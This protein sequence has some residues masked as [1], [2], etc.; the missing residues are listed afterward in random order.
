MPACGTVSSQAMSEPEIWCPKCG[1]RPRAEDR[2]ICMPGCDTSWNTFWTAGL[3]PGCM[4]RWHNTQC[5]VCTRISPHRDWYHWPQP[6]EADQGARER[7]GE[8]AGA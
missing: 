8:A 6:S 2:W 3:C 1:W 7:S 5:L 4:H